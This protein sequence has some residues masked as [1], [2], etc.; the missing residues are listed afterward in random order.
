MDMDFVDYY[1]ILGVSPT[2]SERDLREAY[3]EAARRYHPDANKSPGATAIFQQIN[4]AYE[5]LSDKGRRG[6]YDNL[7]RDYTSTPPSLLLQTLYSRRQVRPINEPQALYILLKVQPLVE[8]NVTS[9]APLNLT[10]VLDRSTSMK[11]NRLQNLKSA[12]HHIMNDLG[13]D[14]VLSVVT[15]SDN[16]EV[17]IPAQYAEDLRSLKANIST[18]RAS[19][20]TAILAGLKAGMNQIERYRHSRYV[21]HLVLITDGRTYGDE[22][23]ALELASQAH[24]RGIGISGMGIGED[25]NDRFLDALASRTGGSSTYIT[26]TKS[27]SQFLEKR[28]RSLATAYAEQARLL[29]APTPQV[30]LMTVARITPDPMM[31]DI[32]TQPFALG[33]VDGTQSSK[34]LLEFRLELGPRKPG[35]LLV[36]RVDIGA[37]VLGASEGTE[38]VFEDLS[39]E[40]A[41]K[42]TDE[43]PPAELLDALSHLSLYRLQSRA[44]DA[45]EDGDIEEATRSLEY[46]ATRLFEQGQEKL[47]QTALYEA[48]RVAQTQSLSD[49]GAKQ[50]KYGTR[51]LWDHSGEQT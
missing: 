4:R 20:A 45:L 14:D 51:A 35:P 15:F 28:I 18:L 32:E 11:G 50:I 38:R 46:L 21:N 42:G 31:F 24:E 7:W 36:G 43:R 37:Q 3:R 27:V 6:D 12:V 13:P 17:L 40:V 33:S 23:E 49:E 41:S 26:S 2:S 10:L 39:V 8:S 25:W 30:G 44:N 9:D 48:R 34:I 29:V 47:G 1:A 19:G 5:V 16:A 22:E